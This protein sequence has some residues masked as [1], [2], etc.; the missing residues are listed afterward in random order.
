[1]P[2][3][4]YLVISFLLLFIPEIHAET[5]I[6]QPVIEGNITWKKEEGPYLIKNDLLINKNS[7]L[8]IEP[9]TKIVISFHR[10]KLIK[11]LVY[12]NLYAKG[13]GNN[14]IVFTS[15]NDKEKS[16][17]G[18][19][20][21][22]EPSSESIIEY[23]RIE[24]ARCAIA[25]FKASPLIKNNILSV[26]DIAIICE[27]HSSPKITGNVIKNN[28]TAETYT[29]AIHCNLWSNPEIYQNTLEKNYGHSIYCDVYSSPLIS[30]NSINTTLGA[31]IVCSSFS[32][33]KIINNDLSK[34]TSEFSIIL[35]NSSPEITA[36][37]IYN[38]RFYGITCVSSS[39]II[40]NNII[41]EN[42]TGI[43]CIN[44][45]GYILENTISHS[46]TGIILAENSKPE[47]IHNNIVSNQTDVKLIRNKFGVDLKENTWDWENKRG[48]S[49]ISYWKEKYSENNATF[50]FGTQISKKVTPDG[51]VEPLIL[52]HSFRE[53]SWDIGLL[54]GST[55]QWVL[56]TKD[57]S[58]NGSAVWSI[59]G[60]FITFTSNREGNW[61]IFTMDTKGENIKNMTKSPS[62]VEEA[63]PMWS[64]DGKKLCYFRETP[65]CQTV[66]MDMESKIIEKIDFSK[67]EENYPGLYPL[68]FMW[69]P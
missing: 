58:Y 28:G 38:K 16:W 30:E 60:S 1:M 7:R 8:I 9:G 2:K 40:Y 17:Q 52:F 11:I 46:K 65:E 56:L 33:P 53:G 39:P 12:G 59:D 37:K 44:S 47:V 6:N 42:N 31:D 13:D 19:I 23:T 62:F 22:G 29:S 45:P 68:V 27:N 35:Y 41:S 63:P 14:H 18:I 50:A 67:I 4:F 55:F 34:G 54:D 3:K 57:N 61:E 69:I 15:E 43:F 36:N 51:K 10:D 26:N 66:I 48:K 32:N 25:C 21:D 24:N 5:A 64:P 49:E 20:F